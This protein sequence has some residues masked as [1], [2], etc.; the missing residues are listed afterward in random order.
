MRRS[1]ASVSSSSS[2][3]ATAARSSAEWSPRAA[4]MVDVADQFQQR[5]ADPAGVEGR[6][7]ITA[8]NAMEFA[9]E[10]TDLAD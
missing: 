10:G 7:V 2:T 8:S 9:F 6:V 4:G 3:A 5:D 1:R